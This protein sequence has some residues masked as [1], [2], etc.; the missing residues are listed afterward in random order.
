MAI[1]LSGTTNDITINGVSV[2]T[3]AEVNSAVAPKANTADVNTQLGLKANTAD[4]KQI[5]VGQTWQDVTAS[6]IRNVTYYNTTGKPIVITA[7]LK[8][9]STGNA[10]IIRVDGVVVVGSY[11]GSTVLS[12]SI[13]T[14]IPIGSNYML[15][16]T[17]H[18]ILVEA[19]YELR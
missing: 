10:V 3:D 4:L 13:T 19:V 5:G 14:V 15:T 11:L 7:L 1:K 2:A 6:R 18:N 17:D 16:G 12:T 9:P 8:P